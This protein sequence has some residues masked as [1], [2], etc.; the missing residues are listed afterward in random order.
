[1]RVLNWSDYIEPALLEE[2]ERQ[3][4]IKVIYDV[5]DSSEALV[6]KLDAVSEPYDLVVPSADKLAA[7]KNDN[8]VKKL[9]PQG[10]QGFENIDSTILKLMQVV[11]P[12]NE[13]GL[14]YLWGTVGIAYNTKLVDQYAPEAPKNSLEMIFNPIH[15]R[16]LANCG[17]AVLD[18][19]SDIIPLALIY[20][21]F[22]PSVADVNTVKSTEAVLQKIKP[23]VKTISSADYID[24]LAKGKVCVAVMFSGDALQARDNIETSG[25][26]EY[27]VPEEGSTLWFD[28]FALSSGAKNEVAA[29]E[30]LSFMMVPENIAQATNYVNYA[31]ANTKAGAYISKDI[32]NDIG[33]YPPQNVADRLIVM[34][35]LT[36]EVS[37]VMDQVWSRFKN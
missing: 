24:A 23:H 2:F 27:R 26:I 25:Q 17:V 33:I 14:P 8:K 11:D 3:T 1:L 31:N 5:F 13:Y 34:P 20:L 37:S 22:D 32:L 36:D 29:R 15:A 18:S 4:K 28:T 21:G 30:F 35:A 16:K 9:N 12:G 6:E 19:P 7:L 10:I